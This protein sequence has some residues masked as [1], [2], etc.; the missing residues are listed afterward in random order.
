MSMV[1]SLRREVIKAGLGAS[2]LFAPGLAKVWAQTEGS[3]KL[4]QLPKIALVIG[5]SKYKES[6]L[7]NPANDAR[8]MAETL[9]SVGFNVTLRMDAGRTELA[10][11]VDAYVKELAARKCVGMF[12]YAGHGIQLAW[13]NYMLPV[14]MD[15]D[16]IADVQKQGVEVHSLMEGLTKAGNAL[17]VIIL[18]ACRDNPFGSLKGADQ[19]GLSQMDAP[20][21]TLLAYA[22]SPGNVASDGEGA[23]GL[24]TENLL[25]EVRVPEAKLEDVFKRVRLS[26]RRRSNGAQIPWE[27]T[28]LEEDFW[29]VPPASLKRAS[30][31]ERA[32]AFR[33]EMALWEKIQHAT[34]P[35]P[36]ENYLRRFP[37]GNYAELAQLQLDRALARQ[38]EKK[39]EIVSS[40]NNPYTKGSAVANT[41][42]K[43]GD[44]YSY[45][46]LEAISRVQQGTFETEITRI[47]DEEVQYSNGLVTDLLGNTRVMRD[48]RRFTANQGAPTELVVGKRWETRFLVTPPGTGTPFETEMSLRIPTRERVEVPAG[49]FDAFRIEARGITSTPKGPIG[50]EVKSWRVPEIRNFL[51]REEIRRWGNNIVAAE[52]VELTA[53]RQG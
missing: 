19:K 46:V 45:R 8:A 15:I 11:A 24:Y 32:K 40:A 49:T 27:S 13:K 47:T 44:R 23:N 9:K 1:N 17:N 33:E 42:Y 34:T 7:K 39:I 51:V 12:Y 48:G 30:E 26:V 25:K 37:N 52:R 38:G 41:S 50:V 31:A 22:T 29:F 35:E 2:V 21:S 10:T 18:D 53:Y 16:S 36:F 6:P 3:M 14:D 5:N 20:P 4:L 28:S 43:V